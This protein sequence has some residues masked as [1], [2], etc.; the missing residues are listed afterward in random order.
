MDPKLIQATRL[1]TTAQPVVSAYIVAIVR[2][3]SARDDLLQNTAVAV[4]ESFDHYDSARPFVGWALG[5]AQNHVRMYLRKLR[6]DRLVFDDELMGQLAR[7]FEET[8]PD[9]VSHR[10]ADYLPDCIKQ[11]EARARK[12]CDLR[13]IDDLKPAAIAERLGMTANTVAK[14]LQRIRDQLRVCI[15]R[16][17]RAEGVIG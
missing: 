2:D 17:G 14:A 7:T 4:L 9:G 10:L 11:L 3:F 13:Y 5:I 15:E 12:M 16:K 8:P 1:W 6:R